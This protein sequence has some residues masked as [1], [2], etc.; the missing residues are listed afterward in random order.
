LHIFHSWT[1]LSLNICFGRWIFYYTRKFIQKIN[2]QYSLINFED[3]RIHIFYISPILSFVHDSRAKLINKIDPSGR[4]RRHPEKD[5]RRRLLL[6]VIE[7]RVFRVKRWRG[8]CQTAFLFCPNVLCPN[9]IWLQN[10]CR[11]VRLFF[12]QISRV[13]MYIKV[14][15]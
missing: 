9:C 10:I 1:F 2:R 4:Q 5:R 11:N 14:P 3:P 12:E 8:F 15:S 6:V 7:S 13:D